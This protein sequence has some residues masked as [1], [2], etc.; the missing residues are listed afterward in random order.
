MSN[1]DVVLVPIT[2]RE[3]PEQ[4]HR[5]PKHGKVLTR[6]FFRVEWIVRQHDNGKTL[7]AD[8]KTK[9]DARE[10]ARLLGY[11][12]IDPGKEAQQDGPIAAEMVDQEK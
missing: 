7:V 11:H 5:Y 3:E 4:F 2:H 8:L 12:I 10:A 9:R 6:H 1:L